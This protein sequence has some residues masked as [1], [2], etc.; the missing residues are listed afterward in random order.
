[1]RQNQMT[2]DLVRETRFEPDDLILPI[3]I[4]QGLN[5]K[6]PIASMPNHFQLSVDTLEEEINEIK[7][8]GIKKI[9]LFGVPQNK[10]ALGQDSYHDQGI[11]QTALATIKKVYPTL[12]VI[13]D[14]CFCEYTDHGHCGFIN[15]DTQDVDNDATLALLGKQAV[16]MVKAGADIIAP[17]GMQDGMVAAIR[18]ALDE[19]G[20][21]H[22][23]IL[24]YAIKYASHFYDP[25][26][27]AA[28]GKMQFG[29]R[30]SYQM[31]FR[32]KTE[33]LREAALDIEEGAD[34]LMVKPAHTY[35]DVI[36]LIKT[37]H[38]SLPLGAYHTS[39]EF[40]LLKAAAEKGWIDEN[41][42]VLE[43]LT[44]IRRAGADFIFTYYAKEVARWLAE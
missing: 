13:T 40:A 12:L 39:G 41:N 38:P 31:D 26:R 7:Q 33:A 23:P 19:A 27:H 10:D 42:A 28:E 20:Y 25:F 43:V 24:S 30:R 29:S 15:K 37:Q 3:F 22:T 1:M 16:S 34:M 32:N 5:I 11:I 18:T 4:K 14:V 36:T 21:A 8:L 35:L 17:S 6:Q 2:R 44:A 9:I